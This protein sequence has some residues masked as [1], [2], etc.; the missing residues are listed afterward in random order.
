MLIDGQGSIIQ[1][2]LG[3]VGAEDFEQPSTLTFNNY[4]L[5]NIKPGLGRVFV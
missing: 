3:P 4:Q 2:W 5:Y 1:Q